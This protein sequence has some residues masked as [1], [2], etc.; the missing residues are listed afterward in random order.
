MTVSKMV[1]EDCGLSLEGSFE[2]SPLGR[3]TPEDQVF[4]VA[5]VRHHG[6]IKKM[7]ALFDVSYPTVKNRLNAIG[8]ALDKSFEAPSPNACRARAARARRDH[9][10]RSD[11]TARL[12]AAPLDRIHSH[13]PEEPM[14]TER[15]QV[16]E[17]LAEGKITTA[18]A[19]RLLDK[20]NGSRATGDAGATAKTPPPAHRS[21]CGSWSTR[22]TATPS[23]SA[24]RCRW[25]VRASSSRPCCRPR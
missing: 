19:D 15:K 14:S 7:E 5:F 9:R 12:I 13:R 22:M 24:C 17:M 4:V 21:S 16:L 11:G 18:D 6:S 1:C 20:L 10:R 3:L 2:V 23:T 25:C 8:A